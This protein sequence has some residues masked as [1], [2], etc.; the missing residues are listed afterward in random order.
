MGNSKICPKCNAKNNPLLSSCW[1]CKSPFLQSESLP[2]AERAFLNSQGEN[3]KK[4]PFC[5]EEI[6]AE[7]IKCK[8]CGSMVG[9]VEPKVEIK[10]NARKCMQCHMEIPQGGSICPYCRKGPGVAGA[11]NSAADSMQGCGC[12]LAILGF[13]IIS[14]VMFPQIWVAI[15]AIF[16]TAFHK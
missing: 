9:A 14:F 8:H 10:K 11:L 7:A 16:S 2:N 3:V 6:K 12:S 1:K 13:I 15:M 4:C 5:A